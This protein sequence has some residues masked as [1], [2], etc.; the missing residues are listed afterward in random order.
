MRKILISSVLGMVLL[1]VSGL[2]AYAGEDERMQPVTDPVVIKE[3]GACHMVYQP[4]FLPAASWT[5]IMADL[6]NH[7]GENAVL[8][9]AIAKPIEA[10]LTANAARNS[11]RMRAASG[12]EPPLRISETAWFK[13]K[14]NK[15]GRSSPENL[16]RHNAK[17]IAQCKACHRD[18]DKGYYEDD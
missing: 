18:A 16:K 5:K 17:T 4:G 11:R 2:T 9:P 7:F 1:A 10:Y 6:K 13:R 12:N 15:R 8:D 14:H 3:C